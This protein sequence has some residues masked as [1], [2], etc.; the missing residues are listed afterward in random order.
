MAKSHSSNIEIPKGTSSSSLF[1]AFSVAARLRRSQHRRRTR[2][3][4]LVELYFY[5]PP[6]SSDRDGNLSPPLAFSNDFTDGEEG[7]AFP[8]AGSSLS[9]SASS[10]YR[11]RRHSPS[12]APL[13]RW[14]S[15]DAANSLRRAFR[16]ALLQQ[17]APLH[18]LSL[19]SLLHRSLREA[20]RPSLN[21]LRFTPSAERF[22]PL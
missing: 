19:S 12:A 3:P 21:A 16:R 4:F 22:H 5:R 13:R 6:S 9:R 1:S 11:R 8:S 20:V 14:L 2:V 7:V 10:Q 15:V 17:A 18:V